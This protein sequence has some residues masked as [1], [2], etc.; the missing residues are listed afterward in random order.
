MTSPDSLAFDRFKVLAWWTGRISNAD[1]AA[2]TGQ[3]ERDVRLIL[4]TPYMR[5]QIKGG[6]RG[7]KNTRRITRQARNAVAIV[8]AL[9]KAGFP[10]EVAANIFNAVPVLA[11]F[12]TEAID[13]SPN[14]L[15]ALPAP[16]G[17]VSM[18]AIE[19]PDGGWLP[20][21]IVPRHVFDLHRRPIAKADAS[22]RIAIGDIGW[23]PDWLE[24]E[25]GGIPDGWIALGDPIYRPEIDPLGIYEH[26]NARPD[27][28]DRLDDHFYIVNGRWIWAR[29]SDPS[30]REYLLDIFQHTELRAER[31]FSKDSFTYS[32]EPIAEIFP[33]NSVKSIRRD[34]DTEAIA[35]R[36][37]DQFHTR[38]DVNAS[39]AIRDMKRVA[40]GTVAPP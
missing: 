25:A 22:N 7:S 18:L 35:R 13:F 30:P 8:A 14:A 24:K 3:T 36:S 16:Y 40:L 19:D 2:W 12:P 20:T 11:S 6:G 38:L 27:A 17:S 10:I 15:E 4:D 29:Y 31:R 26:G 34:A 23:W 39:L 5:S 32:F 33:D 37:W 21:D 28:N 1:L 9:R